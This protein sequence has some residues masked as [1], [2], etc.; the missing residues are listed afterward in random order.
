M[1]MWP[2]HVRQYLNVSA[3]LSATDVDIRIAEFSSMWLIYILCNN[4]QIWTERPIQYQV[5]F[6]QYMKSRCRDKTI[7]RPTFL[8]NEVSISSKT[9]CWNGAETTN[10]WPISYSTEHKKFKRFMF[11]W[12]RYREFSIVKRW[13]WQRPCIDPAGFYPGLANLSFSKAARK[14]IGQGSME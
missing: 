2:S 11:S 1:K 4:V 6:Y 14:R 7:F 9:V 12:V 5:S 13:Y 3:F 8:Q 10:S